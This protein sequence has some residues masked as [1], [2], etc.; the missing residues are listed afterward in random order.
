MGKRREIEAG[1]NL[2]S[3]DA[4]RRYKRRQVEAELRE[5]GLLPPEDGAHERARVAADPTHPEW[6]PGKRTQQKAELRAHREGVSYKVA[7]DREIRSAATARE[8]SLARN[9]AKGDAERDE[10]AAERRARRAVFPKPKSVYD[11]PAGA[12]E[13]DRRRH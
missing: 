8:L 4:R 2:T 9:R 13:T 1:I 11:F 3:A 10:R 5:R 6:K 12:F 7:L